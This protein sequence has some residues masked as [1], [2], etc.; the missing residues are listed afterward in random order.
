[1]SVTEGETR[2][3]FGISNVLARAWE[4]LSANF[5]FFFVIAVLVGIP[6]MIL[7][8]FYDPMEVMRL[9]L[10][11]AAMQSKDG[12]AYIA[13]YNRAMALAY[14]ATLVI[15]L[16]CYGVCSLTV[17]QHL[18]HER[19]AL[20]DNFAQALKR[21]FPL[22]GASLLLGL[23]VGAASILLIIPG[24]MLAVRWAI[25]SQVCVIEKLGPIA[26]LKRS[27]QL[28]KGYRWPL[29]GLGILIA[30]VF[31][32]VPY[33]LSYLLGL[34][35]GRTVAVVGGLL[36]HGVF[37][38]YLYCLSVTVYQELRRIKEGME[39]PATMAVFD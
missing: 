21:F 31:G 28:T 12:A 33:L 9:G 26:S 38:G 2:N 34:A 20:G 19:G 24:I 16:V 17:F 18:R 7:Q 35:G 25:S 15:G 29:F 11:P 14:P 27:S 37:G 3:R 23:G 4:V 36:M 1:M 10:N 39:S 22:L 6:M 30:V 32:L 8:L 13:G 5:A